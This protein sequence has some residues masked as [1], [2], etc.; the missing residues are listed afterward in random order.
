MNY[1]DQ[2][3][4]Q[5]AAGDW[6]SSG[7]RLP[8]HNW[9]REIA[10]R[11]FAEAPDVKASLAKTSGA[12]DVDELLWRQWMHYPRFYQDPLYPYIVAVSYRLIGDDVRWALIDQLLIGVATNVLIWFITLIYFGD[13]AAL[14]AAALAVLYAPMMFYELLLLR[15]S[16]VVFATLSVIVLAEKSRNSRPLNLIGLGLASAAAILLK[17]T[18][19]LV[20]AALF[21]GLLVSASSRAAR[22]RAVVWAA[23]G[24]AFVVAVLVW[25]NVSVGASPLSLAASGPLTFV[26]SNSAGF[27]A[28][29]GFGIDVPTLT[30]F[31][32]QTDGGW[33]AAFRS[34]L[35]TQTLGT[36][37]GLLWNKFAAVWHWY[38]MPNNENFYYMRVVAPVLRW[39][40][41]TFVACGSLGLVGFAAAARQ[42][43]RAWP[44]YVA[45]ST[46]LGTLIVFYVLGRFR[47]GLAALLIPF[48]GFAL[49][50]FIEQLSQRRLTRAGVAAACVGI[51]ALW[52][53]R[54]LSSHQVLI[55]MA[56]WILPY[57]AYYQPRISDAVDERD[58]TRASML[59]TDYF[60]FEPTRDQIISS[61]DPRTAIELAD[62]HRECAQIL[63]LAHNAAGA[64]AQLA[65]AEQLD[66]LSGR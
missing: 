12:S 35:S 41:F 52:I 58:W 17:S 34:A 1:Y 14:F 37:S 65:A 53:G 32:G 43:R 10:A 9:H 42:W 60:R 21:V 40:P 45:L 36:Y 48:A 15:D 16:L 46:S 38:E 33:L 39:M 47:I 55:R 64:A 3:A 20:C 28:D 63:R 13:V 6:R 24:F 31:L 19:V 4:R 5:I 66:A 8:M 56:D 29:M 7:F 62:M 54:P 26:A 30:R 27:A 25:R 59:Y 51:L 22:L 57:S 2:W 18:F 11:F 50:V 44:L 49:L 23:A 61:G